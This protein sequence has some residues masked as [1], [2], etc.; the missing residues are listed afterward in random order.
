MSGYGI[1]SLLKE[2]HRHL[3][4]LEEAVLKNIDACRELAVITRTSYGPNGESPPACSCFVLVFTTSAWDLELLERSFRS[5][6]FVAHA[7]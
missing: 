1:Q 6:L 7:R 2:G 3:S 4:G 5:G